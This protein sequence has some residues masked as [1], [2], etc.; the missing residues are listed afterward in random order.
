[1][2]L[3]HLFGLPNPD[4]ASSFSPPNSIL[5]SE[6]FAMDVDDIARNMDDPVVD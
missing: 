1:V 6:H 3:R 2:S 5:V 4:Y